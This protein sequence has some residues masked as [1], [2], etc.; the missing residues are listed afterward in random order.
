MASYEQL[1]LSKPPETLKL[2]E[3]QQLEFDFFNAPPHKWL[4]ARDYLCKHN[5]VFPDVVLCDLFVRKLKRPMKGPRY[6]SMEKKNT[7]WKNG[8]N[9]V[10]HN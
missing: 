5:T 6:P 4:L 10:T 1:A 2:L 9:E 8:W 7:V 3:G